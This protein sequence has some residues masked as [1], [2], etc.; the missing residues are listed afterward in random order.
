M[1]RRGAQE[2]SIYRRADGL[3]VG[4]VHLGYRD[5]KRR[6]KTIYG[7]TQREVRGKVTAALRAHEQGIPLP[8]DR[9]TVAAFLDGWLVTVRPTIRPS[10]FVSYQGHVRMHLVPALGRIAL[11]RLSPVEIRA[12]MAAK[13]AA[14]LSPRTVQYI[15]AVL[16]RALGQ[17]LRDGLV[18]RNVAAL[19]E[20]PRV[21]RPEV[22]PL[23]PDQARTLLNAVAGDRL[24][25]LYTVALALGLRQGEALGLRWQDVD[26]DTGALRVR[27]SLQPLPR[28]LRPEGAPRGSRLVL[29]EPKTAR[30]RRTVTMPAV[31]V[32][33]LRQHRIGQLQERLL[34]G[35]RWREWGLVFT[36][37]IGT[38][39]EARNVSH[40]FHAILA[41]AGLPRIRFHDLRHSAATLMLAQG[42]SPRVVMETLG[43]STIG[44]T[45]NVYAHVIP[46]LQQD[47]ADRMDAILRPVSAVT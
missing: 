12:L 11:A 41:A 43:H 24:E 40:R 31:V 45:M 13:L 1:A 29:V 37:T 35:S 2:G 21:R 25:A 30:S 5:G 7:K 44:M 6:R 23:S 17:A 14:G 36:T 3:W 20:P 9:L 47:A 27:V 33:A 32:S 46:A 39:L 16:R 4:A 19:V 26:L 22:R 18:A 8:S 15:H 34:A 38:P 28:D 42:V 10:T